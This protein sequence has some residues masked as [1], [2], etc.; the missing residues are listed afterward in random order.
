MQAL[1]LAMTQSIGNFPK[2]WQGKPS[3]KKTGK[4]RANSPYKYILY[5]LGNNIAKKKK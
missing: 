2:K 4:E 1:N 5:T 3:A